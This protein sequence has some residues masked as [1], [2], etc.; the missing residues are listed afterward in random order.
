MNQH[1]ARQTL[2]LTSILA[3][4]EFKLRY[5]GSA[6]GFFWS[7]A[8]PLALFGILYFAFSYVLRF[9]ADVDHYP[10]QLLLAIVLWTFFAEATA[11]STSVLVARADMTRKIS[12]PRIVLPLAVSGTA[13]LAM[14]FNLVAVL[15][16]CIIGGVT[17][18]LSWLWLPLLIIELFVGT[19]GISLLLAAL[20]VKY[21]DIGQIW[22]LSSQ[23]LFYA[24]PIIYPISLVPDHL[25]TLVLSNPLSQ[26][27]QDA[28]YVI[29]NPST[30]TGLESLDWRVRLIPYVITIAVFVIG[31]TVFRRAADRVAEHV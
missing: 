26:I 18:T 10:Q 12:F 15:V 7:V 14:L 19:I 8:K 25:H 20:F 3:R 29:V 22:E 2:S 16:I 17:P 27:I 21:R 4:S 28:R 31:L 5:A 24:T 23:M 6:L 13:A 30:G 1:S 11:A 9:G